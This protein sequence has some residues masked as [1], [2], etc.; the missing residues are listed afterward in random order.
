MKMK[1]RDYAKHCIFHIIGDGR[2]T[3]FWTYNCHPLGP[4]FYLFGGRAIYDAASSLDAKVADFI[5]GNPWLLPYP[6]LMEIRRFPLL[7]FHFQ[8][9]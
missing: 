4:L 1:I 3:F 8:C 6:A 9:I 2:A 7:W 5:Q